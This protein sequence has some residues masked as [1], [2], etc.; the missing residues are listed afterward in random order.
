LQGSNVIGSVNFQSLSTL[1]SSYINLPVSTLTAYKPTSVAY[2]N[3]VTTA[4]QVAVVNNLA[5]LQAAASAGPA[6]SLTILGRVGNNYQVQYCTNFGPG[7]VW[8]P[9]MTYSQT[10]ITQSVSLDPTIV[11]A[12]YRVQQK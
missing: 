2:A 7:A 6:R 4:G 1:P 12:F 5:I 8:Y 9:L 3:A 11:Q 10:S